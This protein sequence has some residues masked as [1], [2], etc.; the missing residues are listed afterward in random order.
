MV[1]ALLVKATES[2]GHNPRDAGADGEH[3]GTDEAG[4]DDVDRNTDDARGRQEGSGSAVRSP[5]SRVGDDR[6]QDRENPD[7]ERDSEGERAGAQTAGGDEEQGMDEDSS[8]RDRNGSERTAENHEQE[9]QEDNEETDRERSDGNQ[10]SRD[11]VQ[12]N[13]GEQNPPNEQPDTHQG[14]S[15]ADQRTNGA[16]DGTGDESPRR[17]DSSQTEGEPFVFHRCVSKETVHT[18]L[19]FMVI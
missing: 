14:E 18:I 8:N 17:R 3:P 15:G 11:Q 2:P 7:T 10:D 16:Q 5:P 6:S 19:L 4:T 13:H 9:Q 12:A 1:G